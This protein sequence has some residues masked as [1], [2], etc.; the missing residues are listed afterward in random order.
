MEKK[1]TTKCFIIL[2]WTENYQE[3]GWPPQKQAMPEGSY[4]GWN[5]NNYMFGSSKLFDDYDFGADCALHNERL[6]NHQIF[7]KRSK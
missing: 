3:Y 1:G 4:P 5:V 2:K 6:T 7:R